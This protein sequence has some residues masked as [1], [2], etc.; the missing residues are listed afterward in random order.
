MMERPVRVA[1]RPLYNG[2]GQRICGAKS[3][4][5]PTGW[6]H[7]TAVMAPSFRCRMHGGAS[8]GGASAPRHKHGRYSRWMSA[9]LRAKFGHARRT[10]ELLQGFDDIAL[11]DARIQVLLEQWTRGEADAATLYARARAAWAALKQ[12]NDSGNSQSVAAAAR[13]VDAAMAP[14]PIDLGALR[15]ELRQEQ[16]VKRRLVDTELRRGVLEGTYVPL[17][18]A[19]EFMRA[20]A[21]AVN[22]HVVN[23][24][25]RLAVQREFAR[26]TIG[27]RS[28]GDIIEAETARPDPV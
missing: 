27:W 12:A 26:L 21:E 22:Q 15:R 24:G 9:A 3:R 11:A 20:L 17:A 5:N 4:R 18:M 7:S 13:V 23:Q 10:R 25:E 16:L 28:E 1:D 8:K 6:C 2:R 19:L 14:A